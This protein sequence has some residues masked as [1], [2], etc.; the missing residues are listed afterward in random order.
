MNAPARFIARPPEIEAAVAAGDLAARNRRARSIAKQTNNIVRLKLLNEQERTAGA[1]EPVEQ[2]PATRGDCEHDE[3]PCPFVGCK[4]HLAI[5][6]TTKGSII[7]NH[8]DA[9]GEPDLEEMPFTC[10]LDV[11]DHGGAALEDIALCM[12]L[13][14]EAARQ[15][16]QRALAKLRTAWRELLGEV[17]S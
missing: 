11:A 10:S 3:R 14:R 5:D 7:V 13:T 1:S 17:S 6:P 15:I 16:E 4:W 9:H 8:P 2:R 12:N